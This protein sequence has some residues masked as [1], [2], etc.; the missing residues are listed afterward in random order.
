MGTTRNSVFLCRRGILSLLL[1]CFAIS[2]TFAQGR[3][4]KGKVSSAAEGALPGVNV[5][6][7][8]TVTGAMTDAGGNFSI[9]VPGP[10]AVLVFSSIGYTSQSVTV[11]NSTTIDVV[12]V[13]T[14]STLGEVVVVG[15]GT[16][17]KRETT[18]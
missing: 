13:P 18:S 10:E 4:V 7:Q 17:K 15:Y 5:V 12:L 9:T 11:G 1:F 14:T 8:G 16:Q 6:L 2:F 3:V